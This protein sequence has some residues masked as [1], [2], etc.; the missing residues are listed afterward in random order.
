MAAAAAGAQSGAPEPLLLDGIPTPAA[1]PPRLPSRRVR[2]CVTGFNTFFANLFA[3]IV[4]E[5]PEEEA[6]TAPPRRK[7]DETGLRLRSDGKPVVLSEKAKAAVKTASEEQAL[8]AKG[9]APATVRERLQ[10][11]GIDLSKGSLQYLSSLRLAQFE[12]SL[13]PAKKHIYRRA[14]EQANM[15]ASEHL[16]RS[17]QPKSMLVV[18]PW[19]SK[20]NTQ[21]ATVQM[22]VHD[23]PYSPDGALLGGELLLSVS[24]GGLRVVQVLSAASSTGPDN[25]IRVGTKDGEVVLQPADEQMRWAWVL[26]LNAGLHRVAAVKCMMDQSA[27][28]LPWHPKVNVEVDNPE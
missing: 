24:A 20:K 1:R 23:P 16:K 5:S 27:I 3:P 14:Q 17:R 2:T 19:G 8:K 28:A 4:T 12:A 13:D 26:A 25:V 15:L 18:L 22:K 7:R 11:D 10:K 9:K 6:G 21:S